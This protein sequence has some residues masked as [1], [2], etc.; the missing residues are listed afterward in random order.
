MST[1]SRERLQQHPTQVRAVER[2][3]RL[4]HQVLPT[5]IRIL[6]VH[7]KYSYEHTN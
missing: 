1:L 3:G 2:E 5:I 7:C 4:L 6:R